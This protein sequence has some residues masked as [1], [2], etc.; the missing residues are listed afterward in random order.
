MRS[1]VVPS[2]DELPDNKAR[3]TWAAVRLT[4]GTVEAAWRAALSVMCPGLGWTGDVESKSYDACVFGGHVILEDA[5]T[6]LSDGRLRSRNPTHTAPRPDRGHPARR[7]GSDNAGPHKPRIPRTTSTASS[8]PGP[9]GGVGH[10]RSGPPHAKQIAT[11]S[12]GG[13][14]GKGAT[15]LTGPA[16][17]PHA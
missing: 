7:G 16:A 1:V 15:R 13:W 17:A 8:R 6:S 2:A 9:S 11:P 3:W 4:G 10:S 12:R 5:D 14:Q